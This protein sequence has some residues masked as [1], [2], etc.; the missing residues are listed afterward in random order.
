MNEMTTELSIDKKYERAA[1]VICRQGSV[2]F[3]VNQ[4]VISILKVIIADKVEELDFI[5]RRSA[6]GVG[7]PS[8]FEKQA[9]HI[10][11]IC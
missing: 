2:T 7:S 4:T 11:I 8:P 6:E 10:I 3:P 9:G 5:K 1:Q